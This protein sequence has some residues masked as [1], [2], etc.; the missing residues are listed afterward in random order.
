MVVPGLRWRGEGGHV[1]V[2]RGEE[3]QLLGA[4]A[5]GHADGVFVLPGTHSKWVSL[6]E[7]RVERFATYLSG[8]L[9][10]LLSQH[11]TLAPLMRESRDDDAAFAEG[12]AAAAGTA[13]SNALFECRARVVSGE[14]P[15]ASAREHLSGILIGSEWHDALWRFTAAHHGPLHLIGTPALAQRH[16]HAAQQLGVELRIL[17]AQGLQCSAWRRLSTCLD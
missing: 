12:L 8:E 15:A 4:V 2:M 11:G 7:G 14:M 13:L 10:A 3:T 5:Q 6:R 1:D 9:F 17:D 16:Q